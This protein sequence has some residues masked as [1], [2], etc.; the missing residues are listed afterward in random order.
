MLRGIEEM[1]RGRGY[2]LVLHVLGDAERR[3]EFFEQLPVR[4]R[5]DALLLV[6]LPGRELAAA[7]I[8]DWRAF[9]DGLPFARSAVEVLG[10]GGA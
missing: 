3:R 6:A 4:R 2:D 10:E 8:A 1:L 5:V 7:R 9:A